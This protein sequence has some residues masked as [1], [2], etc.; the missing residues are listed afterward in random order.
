MAGL[1][2]TSYSWKLYSIRNLHAMCAR[3]NIYFR[4]ISDTIAKKG[5]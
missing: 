3:Y 1:V 5:G 2:A 4:N